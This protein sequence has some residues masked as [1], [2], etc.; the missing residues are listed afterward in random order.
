MLSVLSVTS[1]V[2]EET[3]QPEA[4]VARGFELAP[5]VVCAAPSSVNTNMVEEVVHPCN[6]NPC[7]SNHLCQV[8]RKG[9]LDEINCQP[10]V[11][12]PGATPAPPPA[13][14]PSPA[15]SFATAPVVALPTS[16]PPSF[17][18]SPAPASV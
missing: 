1:A 6:P 18:P 2:T 8:N 4:L 12:V 15:P 14:G 7:P 17:A 5:P 13:A 3:Q 11:C 16:H 9:C 10:F